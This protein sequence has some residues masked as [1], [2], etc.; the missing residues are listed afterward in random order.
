MNNQY[1]KIVIGVAQNL[2]HLWPYLKTYKKWAITCV[3]FVLIREV[4]MLAEPGIFREIVNVFEQYFGKELDQISAIWQTIW[5]MVGF[6]VL[7]ILQLGAYRGM[8]NALTRLDSMVMRDTAIDFLINV[9]GLS[10]RFHSESQSGR[11]AKE[12][13]RGVSAVESFIDAFI[14][15]LIPL[16]MR[17][18][19]MGVV[20]AFLDWL[21]AVVVLVLALLF[22]VYT[23][24]ATVYMQNARE[25][26]NETDDSSTAYGMDVLMNAVTMKQF[27]QEKK[28]IGAFR[29]MRNSWQQQKQTEWDGWTN[30][31]TV[32][33]SMNVFAVGALMT[34]LIVRLFQEVLTIA[35]FVLII[36]YITLLIGMLWEFQHHF[37][38]V[39]ESLT[40]LSD[41]FSYFGMSNEI[42]DVPNADS[43]TVTQGE[44]EFDNVVFGYGEQRVLDGLSMRIP[45]GS[46]AAIVGPSGA[47]K[48]TALQV[49]SR[50]YDKQS[51]RIL[52]DGQEIG[53]VTQ[54]SLRSAISVVGQ[55]PGMLNRTVRENIALGN[56]E[57]S[58]EAIEEAAKLAYAHDFIQQLPNGYDTLVGE[59]GVRLS[60]GQIQ[61]IAIAR[62]ILRD[63][64]II[65]LDEAT[66]SLDSESER[67][68]QDALENL[69]EDRTVLVIAHRLSTIQSADII[70]V[71]RDGRV[72]QMGTHQELMQHSGGLYKRLWELQ[73]G[74][75]IE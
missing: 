21:L 19:A 65:F 62:A 44:I 33:S 24:W 9:L 12:F 47:G 29:S 46:T 49:L 7:H 1:K 32:Q 64:P 35:D 53:Q 16:T 34:T 61:R 27:Q 74:G 20:F 25:V 36:T 3:A 58:H 41:F 50:N 18:L 67:F 8:F 68:I 45:A 54:E 26:A 43:L 31:S 40:D 59:R 4:I 66:A 52:I 2:R 57:A 70:V 22:V 51:G 75:Y 56:P 6:A 10:V 72:E 48:S 37:R 60:G 14:F 11:L 5:L 28:S 38:R 17:L 55:H 42:T 23:I 13:G 73:A 15:S 69:T 39:N 63:A 30:I 71:M